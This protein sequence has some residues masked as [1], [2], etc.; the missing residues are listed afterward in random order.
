MAENKR[1]IGIMGHPD[2]GVSEVFAALLRFDETPKS[3]YYDGAA[4]C[5]N[6]DLGEYADVPKPPYD[7]KQR[8]KFK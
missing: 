1:N 3:D 5:D 4:V 8:K 2:G 7:A 6:V